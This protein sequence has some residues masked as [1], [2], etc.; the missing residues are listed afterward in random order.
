M[1]YCGL[2]HL[3]CMQE[4]AKGRHHFF[5]ENSTPKFP[6]PGPSCPAEQGAHQYGYRSEKWMERC[7]A[8]CHGKRSAVRLPSRHAKG[9]RCVAA[10][11][12]AADPDDCN[13]SACIY[14]ENHLALVP[15]AFSGR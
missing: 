4:D 14:Q 15:G 8:L 12:M 10:D 11:K 9:A 5:K 7:A 13:D 2:L 6:P 3:E 1:M